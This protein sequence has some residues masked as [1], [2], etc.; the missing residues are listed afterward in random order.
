[1]WIESFIVRLIKRVFK[2]DI[3]MLVVNKIEKDF[4]IGM[5]M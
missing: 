2:F 3:Y 5:D 4:L 1:M